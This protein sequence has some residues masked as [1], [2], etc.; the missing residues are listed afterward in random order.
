MVLDNLRMYKQR[1]RLG[2]ADFADKAALSE[3]L[4]GFVSHC[5]E[6]AHPFNWSTKSVTKVMAK[7][8]HALAA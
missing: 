6:H 1:K 2:I 4:M 3:R 5:N 8:Q 7:C